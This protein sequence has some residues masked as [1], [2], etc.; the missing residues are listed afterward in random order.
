MFVCE[1]LFGSLN[2]SDIA[3]L[4]GVFPVLRLVFLLL[5]SGVGCLPSDCVSPR[6]LL[7]CC[8]EAARGARFLF[9][10]ISSSYIAQSV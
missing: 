10:L 5:L 4:V 6:S 7:C 9:I 3:Q 1:P 2:R 8:E